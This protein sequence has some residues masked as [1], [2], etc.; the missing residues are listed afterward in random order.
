MSYFEDPI[1]RTLSYFAGSL[2]IHD[3]PVY[4]GKAVPDSILPSHLSLSQMQEGGAY[5]EDNV[6]QAL[7]DTQAYYILYPKFKQ[8][9]SISDG[10]S[11][12][13]GMAMEA[14][15]EMYTTCY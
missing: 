10:N 3:V 9:V 2:L 12:I 13:L 11:Q 8:I 7:V 14:M 1:G 15:R 5:K 6:G 4:G